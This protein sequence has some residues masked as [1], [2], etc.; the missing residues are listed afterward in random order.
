MSTRAIESFVNH[1]SGKIVVIGL[2]ALALS[3][4][5]VS[6]NNW[7]NWGSK[8]WQ[9][10]DNA[11]FT[12]SATAG[13][14]LTV[15]GLAS[16]GAGVVALW[17]YSH[18]PLAVAPALAPGGGGGGGGRGDGGGGGGGTVIGGGGIG[19]LP[20]PVDGGSGGGGGGGSGGRSAIIGGGSSTLP[21][22]IDG[23]GV[24]RPDP[25]RTG[26]KPT[27]GTI[28]VRKA[29]LKLTAPIVLN[30]IDPVLKQLAGRTREAVSRRND[31]THFTRDE[32]HTLIC[33][34]LLNAS[35]WYVNELLSKIVAPSNR[36]TGWG[37]GELQANLFSLEQR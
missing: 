7:N 24:L 12:A 13:T 10:W 36:D 30:P 22:S 1:H 29:V 26:K 18:P 34:N 31:K 16:L 5:G 33:E 23:G 11:T 14:L 3:I 28:I 17:R 37:N 6:L 35:G 8:P 21:S 9:N 20:L 19:V 32:L 25:M 27:I 15:A 4:Y 2:V